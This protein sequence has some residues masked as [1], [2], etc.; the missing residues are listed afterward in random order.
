LAAKGEVKKEAEMVGA[1]DEAA[2]E[3]KKS[4]EKAKKSGD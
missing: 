4:R 2:G 3:T 1:K